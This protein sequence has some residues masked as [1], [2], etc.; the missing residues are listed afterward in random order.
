MDGATCVASE[1]PDAVGS[2]V[3]ASDAERKRSSAA[4]SFLNPLP[5]DLN[6]DGVQRCLNGSATDP[7]LVSEVRSVGLARTQDDPLTAAS[8]D[9]VG[10]PLSRSRELLGPRNLPTNKRYRMTDAVAVHGASFAPTTDIG[11]RTPSAPLRVW[12][13]LRQPHEFPRCQRKSA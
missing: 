1:I 6:R 5:K 9:G 12:H 13:R 2:T 4:H 11:A 7:T 8:T 10:W 3:V